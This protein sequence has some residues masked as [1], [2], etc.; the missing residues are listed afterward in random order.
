MAYFSKISGW[1]MLTVLFAAFSYVMYLDFNGG[2]EPIKGFNALERVLIVW[3]F[4]TLI[5]IYIFVAVKLIVD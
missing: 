3:T 1:T 4:V 5:C 2:I